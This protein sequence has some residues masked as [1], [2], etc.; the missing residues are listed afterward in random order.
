MDAD[1]LIGAVHRGRRLPG[2]WGM[3]VGSV[4]VE[5]TVPASLEADVRVIHGLQ[6]E[7]VDRSGLPDI[8]GITVDGLGD[9]VVDVDVEYMPLLQR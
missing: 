5:A 3:F 9:G 6:I 7:I 1:G 4:A 2:D 8:G